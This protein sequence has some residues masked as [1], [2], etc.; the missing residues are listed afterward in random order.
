MPGARQPLPRPA[1]RGR[2][3]GWCGRSAT[4]DVLAD[5]RRRVASP[6]HVDLAGPSLGKRPEQRLTDREGLVPLGEGLVDL[7]DN[8]V[9]VADVAVRAREVVLEEDVVRFDL[10]Q[11]RPDRQRLA[12]GTEGLVGLVE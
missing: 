1:A 4:A 7:A 2:G 6:G 3:E 11:F 5:N 8:A 9:D 12:V 10:D